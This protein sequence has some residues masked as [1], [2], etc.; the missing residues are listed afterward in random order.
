MKS[1][2]MPTAKAP[3]HKMSRR[4]KIKATILTG[5][6]LG[7]GAWM[8]AKGM[9]ILNK[10]GQRIMEMK[11]NLQAVEQ[12]GGQINRTKDKF[13]KIRNVL[14]AFKPAKRLNG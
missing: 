11:R 13:S 2:P 5:A 12:L 7:A 8:G 14:K 3:R 10:N 1:L 9:S 4:S 6:G